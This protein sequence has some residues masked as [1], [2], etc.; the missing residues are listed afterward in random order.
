MRLKLRMSIVLAV[1]GGLLFPAAVGS[2]M[3]LDYQKQT[4]AARLSSDHAR[5]TE[6]LALGAEDPLWNVNPDG[7][8]PLFESVLSDERVVQVAIRDARFGV[9]LFDE[10]P[11]RRKGQQ[12]TLRRD[13]L[14]GGTVIGDVFVE[15]DTGQFE[16]GVARA[17]TILILTVLGQLLLS[18]VLI[19]GLL[20]ARLLAPIRQLMRDSDRLARRELAEPFVWQRDDELGSLGSGLERT[21]QALRALFG[22]L[23]TKNQQLHADIERRID[24]ERELERHREHLTER[25]DERTA[26]LQVA[27]ER[28]EVANRAKSAFLA[29][30][31]HELRTPLNAIL[32]HVQLLQDHAGFDERTTAGLHTIRRSGELLL[33]LINDVLDLSSI[34]AGKLE[35]NP[36]AVDLPA[37][38]RTVADM[39]R[40]KA[41]ENGLKFTLDAAGDVPQRVLVDER[42]LRQVLLNLLSNAVKFTAS[43][44]VAL[45]V[46]A[47]QVADGRVRLRFEVED[48][49]VGIDATQLE[50][51]FKPFE[52]TPD[53]QRRFGGTGLGLSISRALV[54][55][56][57]SEIHVDSRI[58]DGSRFWF[59][60]EPPVLPAA[61]ETGA[62]PARIIVGYRGARRTVL[63]VDDVETSR[64]PLVHF[65]SAR[66]FDV[67]EAENGA[68]ALEQAQTVRPD[69]I[70][71]DARMPVMDGLEATRRLRQLPALSQVPIIA[72]SASASPADQQAS[73]SVGAN[74]FLPKPI[75]LH[76]LLDEIGRL[77][78]LAWIS[79][80]DEAM[81]AATAEPAAPP[82]DEIETLYRLAQIG[83]MQ[84]IRLQADHLATLDEAYRPL[85][86][87]LHAL[88]ERYQS[89]AILELVKKLRDA[90][91]AS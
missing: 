79:D 39:I 52:Q 57:G 90:R 17:R 26:E 20:N 8:R 77:L 83:N 60:L 10:R 66:G 63:T 50:A 48:S 61:G 43:G 76:R 82:G 88:A 59:E 24:V 38:L 29:S 58:G 2:L 15:M 62:P 1:V 53:A 18:V 22:E 74:L 67:Y 28:A 56:M 34:E 73:L 72:V 13:V 3:T 9:F 47:W 87:R 23:E 54:R 40:V 65:L 33:A 75:D 31:S 86:Q 21:R 64:T 84:S 6:A 37:L 11:Q 71:M 49:G 41:Q 27:K 12:F 70:L 91:A 32:G 45:T 30:M 78:Q 14:H 69:L 89:R 36:D 68:A 80:A 81:A 25:I 16:A 19:V 51:I 55:L 46:R 85:A 4:L 7:A 5:L 35:L 44:H 42:R